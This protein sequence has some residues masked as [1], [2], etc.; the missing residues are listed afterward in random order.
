M[1]E[2]SDSAVDLNQLAYDILILSRNTL[3]VNLR[4]LD[5]A[6]SQLEFYPH[7]GIS[8]G[9]EGH[10]LAYSPV[11]IV[12]SYLQD[13]ALPVRYYLHTILHCVFRHMYVHTLVDRDAWDLACDIAVEYS[14]KGLN[15]KA[16]EHHVCT[17]YEGVFSLLEEK[18]GFLTAEKIYHFF[19]VNDDRETLIREWSE[20]FRRDSHLLWNMS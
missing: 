1:N 19:I 17:E 18:V 8:I 5:A 11:F 10:I 2:I 9:S 12:Q 15:I 14:I 7:V 3:L 20:I 13:Q 16:A 4:F 6:L